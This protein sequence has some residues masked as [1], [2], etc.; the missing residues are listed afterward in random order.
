MRA[1]E[2]EPMKYPVVY[3]ASRKGR[4][5]IFKAGVFRPAIIMVVTY[6]GVRGP[7]CLAQGFWHR[8]VSMWRY[9]PWRDLESSGAQDHVLLRARRRFRAALQD[10]TRRGSARETQSAADCRRVRSWPADGATDELSSNF[11][12]GRRETQ[13]ALARAARE[14]RASAASSMRVSMAADKTRPSRSAMN[15][16]TSAW[17]RRSQQ[18]I[19]PASGP[20]MASTAARRCALPARCSRRSTAGAV[21]RRGRW[22]RS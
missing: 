19:A 16:V 17:V 10:V 1:P 13:D 14:A 22:L 4:L 20:I 6:R 9:Q 21:C 2:L 18:Q 11:R 12:L 8:W 7:V 15:A 3:G 5:D